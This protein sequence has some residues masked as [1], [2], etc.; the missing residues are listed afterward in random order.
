MK[1][2]SR[3]GGNMMWRKTDLNNIDMIWVP[4]LNRADQG[5]KWTNI[6]W[7]I[8]T[9][10]MPWPWP[11]HNLKVHNKTFLFKIYKIYVISKYIMNPSSKTCFSLIMNHYSAP[12]ISDYIPTILDRVGRQPLRSSPVPTWLIIYIYRDL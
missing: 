3:R 12:I 7:E 11:E 5:F 4:Q 9:S 2:I 8:F 10:P 6:P 1:M